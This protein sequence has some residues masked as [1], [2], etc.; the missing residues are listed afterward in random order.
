MKIS[1]DVADVLA[2][3][4]VEEDKS[5]L[6][7]LPNEQFDR[8]LYLNVNK[9]LVAIG[10]KW[11]RS[12]GAH[13]FTEPLADTLDE[14]LL[15][16]EYTNWKKDFQFYETPELLALK[17]VE[18]AGILPGEH[19]LEPSAGLGSIAQFMPG[20][21][22]VELMPESSGHLIDEGYNVVGEDFI[23]FMSN[24]YDV[25]VANPPFFRQQ[26]IDHV[27]HMLDLAKRRVVSVMSVSVLWRSN[28]KAQ[29]FRDRIM[30]LG[31]T[32]EE[33]PEGMFSESGTSVKTC[34][35]CVDV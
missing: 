34:I 20:C 13:I 14:I 35:V 25:I 27:N 7:Y 33:L 9:V 4:R 23:Q 16:G 21:D 8:K 15:T 30:T 28:Q 31:G 12:A 24:D 11:N 17:L 5:Y 6:L 26:D 10:G 32:F 19:V 22:C 18:M 1:N 2:N 29:N 3:S